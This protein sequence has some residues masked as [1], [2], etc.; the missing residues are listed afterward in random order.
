MLH[1]NMD[2]RS[3][4]AINCCDNQPGQDTRTDNIKK[5]AGARLPIINILSVPVSNCY[6]SGPGGL[7]KDLVCDREQSISGIDC[8][9]ASRS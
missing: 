5:E 1:V 3:P 7:K 2:G 4:G 8:S 6:S 9:M